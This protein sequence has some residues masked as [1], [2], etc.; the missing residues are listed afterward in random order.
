M[1]NKINI[2]FVS[3]N[4]FSWIFFKKIIKNKL[5]NIKYILTKKNKNNKLFIKKILK[6]KIKIIYTQSI[7][8]L[9]KIKNKLKN[10]NLDLGIIISYGF[11]IPKSIIKIPKFGFINIHASLLPKWK[12]PAP[13][14]WSILSNDKNTGI[15]I[16]KINK[17]IDEGDIIYQKKILIKKKDNYITLFKKIQKIGYKILPIIIIKIFNKNIKYIKQKIIKNKY[18]RKIIKKDGLIIWKKDKAEYIKKKIKAFYKWPKTFFYYLNKIFFIWSISI[19]KKLKKKNIPGKILKYNKNELIICTKNIP[20]K[21][22]KIQLNNKKKIKISNL[23]Y[24]QPKLFIIN[25]ILK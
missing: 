21:I 11:I 10:I 23:F 6:K 18:A 17:N 8:K 3:I 4:D 15:T 24:S 19:I 9:K 1:K 25:K 22:K 2:L 7:K 16:I 13:I 5:F 14:Q 12:G 20:I